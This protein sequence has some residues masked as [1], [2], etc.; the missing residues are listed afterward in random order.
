MAIITQEE[1][2]RR[3][4]SEKN[5]IN[6]LNISTEEK[7]KVLREKA[8][9][10]Q[11]VIIGTLASIDSPKDT[12]L[13]LGIDIHEVIEAKA[14]IKQDDLTHTALITSKIAERLTPQ[15]VSGDDRSVNINFYVPKSRVESDYKVVDLSPI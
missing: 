7:D 2:A 6:S 1:L 15:A 13:G 14:A 4:G 8:L 12:A 9:A 5:L 11:K 3:L 10:S